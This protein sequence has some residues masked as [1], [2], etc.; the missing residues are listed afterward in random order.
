MTIRTVQTYVRCELPH[1]LTV[2]F[3]MEQYRID[4]TTIAEKI[5]GL[6]GHEYIED[7]VF[8]GI[9]ETTNNDYSYNIYGK[10]KFW[11]KDYTHKQIKFKSTFKSD[12]SDLCTAI[13]F[14]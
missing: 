12:N 14:E 3:P 6:T 5:L 9:T 8:T 7:V 4:L 2:Q 1:G 11:D 10:L 13:Q